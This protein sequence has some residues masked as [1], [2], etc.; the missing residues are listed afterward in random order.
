MKQRVVAHGKPCL[1]LFLE[2][3]FKSGVV[4][5]YEEEFK[6]SKD[7]AYCVFCSVEQL[8]Y[9]KPHMDPRVEEGSS[10]KLEA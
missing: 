4:E 1:A 5:S 10:I 3:R 6:K 2:S 9:F 8:A 7:M